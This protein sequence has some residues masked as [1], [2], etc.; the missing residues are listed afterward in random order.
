MG[1]KERNSFLANEEKYKEI[2]IELE[3]QLENLD[4][5]NHYEDELEYAQNMILNQSKTINE[6]KQILMIK[7]KEILGL[8]IEIKK[9]NE[10]KLELEDKLLK[11]K[12]EEE[13]KNQT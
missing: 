2:I 4:S 9:I 7:D 10:S 5:N 3:E 8:N 12:K 13:I 6:I 11:I 1:N